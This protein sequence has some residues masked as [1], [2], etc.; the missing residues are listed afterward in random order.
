MLKLKLNRKQCLHR[1]SV[2][3]NCKNE[4]EQKQKKNNRFW[5]PK[6]ILLCCWIGYFRFRQPFRNFSFLIHLHNANASHRILLFLSF[7][8]CFSSIVIWT[9]AKSLFFPQKKKKTYFVRKTD[10]F[11]SHSSD[12]KPSTL[13][14]FC[15]D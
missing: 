12:P 11:V 13:P 4:N 5:C 6:N 3:R 1:I 2:N 15:F 9:I 8:I 10:G 7:V 14:R